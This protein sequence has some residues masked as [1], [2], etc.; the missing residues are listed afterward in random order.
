[1][2]Y[3]RVLV[4]VAVV[5]EVLANGESSPPPPPLKIDAV[6]KGKGRGQTAAFDALL[7]DRRCGCHAKEEDEEEAYNAVFGVEIAE[8]TTTALDVDE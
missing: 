7:R 5:A 6:E 2:E 1:M 3:R 4:A 8:A